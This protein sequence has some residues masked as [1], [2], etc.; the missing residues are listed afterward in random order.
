MMSSMRISDFDDDETKSHLK[1]TDLENFFTVHQDSS[2]RYFYN[3]NSTLYFSGDTS[4]LPE[5]TCTAPSHWTLI[6]Y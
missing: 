3:L 1:I 5:Y 6:S 2:K 4:S